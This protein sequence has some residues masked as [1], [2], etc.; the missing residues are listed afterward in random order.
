MQFVTGATPAEVFQR[1]DLFAASFASRAEFQPTAALDATSYV[2]RLMDRYGLQ[3]INTPDPAAPNGGT[4]VTF[5]RAELIARLGSGALSRAQV[6]RAV[7]DSDQVAA[8]EFNRGFVTIQ[9][10]G[11]LRRDPEA[12]GFQA[13]LNYLNRNPTDLYTMVN[14]F[15]N[16]VEYR[17]R[18]GRP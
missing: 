4:K 15:V 2:N 12:A 14:G 17:L 3:S 7:A 5:T 16:S 11:Y 10:F 8:A 6:L 13:W 9:Y 1:R 18:F